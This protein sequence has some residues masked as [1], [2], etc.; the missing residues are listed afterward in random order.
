MV[1]TGGGETNKFASCKKSAGGDGL[2][3]MVYP[4]RCHS[5][6]GGSMEMCSY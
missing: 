6:I 2:G 5:V 4:L 1:G 3:Q